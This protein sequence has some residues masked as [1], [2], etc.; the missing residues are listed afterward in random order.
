M[1]GNN[2]HRVSYFP[3]ST[4]NEIA[5]PGKFT[6]PFYYEPHPLAKI[7]AAELQHYL[8]T[9]TDLDHY[10]GLTTGRTATSTGKMFGILV[11]RD[12]EGT[13]AYL[14]AFSG[15]L[16]GSNDHPRF[17]PPVFDMLAANSFFPKGI[18]AIDAVTAQLGKITADENYRRLKNEMACL[19]TQSSQEIASFKQLLTANK[20]TRKKARNE[21]K[22]RLDGQE[23][24]LFEADLAAQS[25]YDKHRLKQ[26]TDRWL[27]LLEDSRARLASF[28]NRIEALKKERRERSAALQEQLFE[29]YTFLN[30]DGQ[31]K[32]LHDIFR[33]TSSGKAPAAAGECATPKLLQFAFQNGYQ[34]IAMAEF[35]WGASP[36]SEI[37][38]HKQFYP[39]CT[40]KC[41]PILAHMLEGIPIDEDPRYYSLS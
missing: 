14:S 35:W 36:K 4:T 13:I 37:R 24:A 34:P 30:K 26:L 29:Q 3:G 15:K 23:Y 32:S 9:Q 7:A 39:A 8:E 25:I 40:P 6:F 33:E 18:T 41:Q 16:A 38:Q 20:E 5:P 10:F 1:G 19:S 11:I 22:N 17:V 2:Q 12:R 27:L 21:Q 31:D 28:E